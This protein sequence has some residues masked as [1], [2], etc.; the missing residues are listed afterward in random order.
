M[1]IYIHISLY[2]DMYTCEDIFTHTHAKSHTCTGIHT[3]HTH[4]PYTRTLETTNHHSTIIDTHIT[5][6][7]EKNL[8]KHI[9][10]LKIHKIP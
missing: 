9:K 6:I 1:W 5:I 4:A 3:H 10:V 7:G 2:V 8:R